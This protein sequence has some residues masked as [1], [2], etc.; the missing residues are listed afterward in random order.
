MIDSNTVNRIKRASVA[1]RLRVIEIILQ[2]LRI[3]IKEEP[4]GKKSKQF[5]VRQFDLGE[6]VHVDRDELYSER[7]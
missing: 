2:S 7:G 1:E 4:P 3:D 5:K 6:E